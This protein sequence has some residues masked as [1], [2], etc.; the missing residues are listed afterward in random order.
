MVAKSGGFKIGDIVVLG[1]R[2]PHEVVVKGVEE[3]G[4]YFVLY[5]V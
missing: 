1:G 4:R 2:G 5:A 3:I